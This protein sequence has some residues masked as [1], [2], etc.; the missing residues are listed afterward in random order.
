MKVQS[1]YAVLIQRLR[2][3]T[4]LFK[5]LGSELNDY[6]GREALTAWVTTRSSS[7]AALSICAPSVSY[8]LGCQSAL[9]G[10]DPGQQEERFLNQKR[11]QPKA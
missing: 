11:A 8:A 2:P 5:H 3:I 6:S 10:S 7:L 1:A 9:N 4:L